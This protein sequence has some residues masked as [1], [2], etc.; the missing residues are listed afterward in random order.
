[1]LGGTHFL[2]RILENSFLETTISD[3]IPG[4]N[5]A[6]QTPMKN[7]IAL[8]PVKFVTTPCPMVK[9]AS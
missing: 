6:S 7:R 4:I 8:R 1:M 3:L 2:F 5:P 9:M